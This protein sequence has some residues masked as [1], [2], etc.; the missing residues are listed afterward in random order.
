MLVLR[1]G[2][3]V[4]LHDQMRDYLEAGTK[5]AEDKVQGIATSYAGTMFRSRLEAGW[6]STLDGYGIRWEY[7]PE[8]VTLGSGARYLPDFRLPELAT[9]IEVKGPHMQRL[10]KTAEYA[11]EMA[12]GVL[13]LIGY[14]PQFRR[15]VEWAGTPL[16]Q[17]GSPLAVMTAFTTCT[18]CGAYQWCAPRYSMDCR[19]CGRRLDGHFA[20]CGEMRFEQWQDEGETFES[21]LAKGGA[22]LNAMVPRGRRLPFPPQGASD[23]PGSKGLVGDRRLVVERPSHRWGRAR[24]RARVTRRLPRACGRASRC[25]PMEASP[26]RMAVPRVGEEKPDERGCGKRPQGS[27]RTTETQARCHVVTA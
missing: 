17:W 8:L 20:G 1:A 11:R 3:R 14:P 25:G 24:Q 26:Q 16:M 23:I 15:L 27:G 6:A 2:D 7:E 13:V 18:A 10:D 21:I 9:V 22:G 19:N 5:A 4:S 12:P